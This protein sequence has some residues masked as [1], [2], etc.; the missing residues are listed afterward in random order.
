[1]A[2]I[3]VA[4]FVFPSIGGVVPPPAGFDEPTSGTLVDDRH[5]ESPAGALTAEMINAIAGHDISIR[6]RLRSAIFRIAPSSVDRDE[7]S[8]ATTFLG[9]SDG[10]AMPMTIARS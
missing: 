10:A 4:L 5:Y 6:A 8:R 7:P 1:M 2:A 3:V 9:S